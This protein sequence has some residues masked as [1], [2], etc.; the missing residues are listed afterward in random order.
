MVA[1]TIFVAVAQATVWSHLRS[2][3]VT[4]Q[5]PSLPPPYGR[6]HVHRYTTHTAVAKVTNALNA[7]HIAPRHPTTSGACAGGFDVTLKL[8]ARTTQTLTAYECGGHNYGGIAGDVSGFVSA[9]GI[10]AP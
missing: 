8:V 5:N 1:A 3:T 10:P 2:A 4:V 9:L 6:A 7:N